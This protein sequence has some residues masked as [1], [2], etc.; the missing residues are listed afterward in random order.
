MIEDDVIYSAGGFA[1]LGSTL[2]NIWRPLVQREKTCPIR[3]L[4]KNVLLTL[5]MSICKCPRCVL[6]FM[7]YSEHFTGIL[8]SEL[9]FR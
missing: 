1:S 5:E 4:D 9:G 7:F 8:T 6:F 3:G 2:A